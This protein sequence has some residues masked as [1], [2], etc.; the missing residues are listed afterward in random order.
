M[1][2]QSYKKTA[3]C[4]KD[5][6]FFI[7]FSAQ[8][9]RICFNASFRCLANL[10]PMPRMV[11]GNALRHRVESISVKV[12]DC[13]DQ[14]WRLSGRGKA[15]RG[16]VWSYLLVVNGI[17]KDIKMLQSRVRTRYLNQVCGLGPQAT[18][19]IYV[20][21]SFSR[22]CSSYSAISRSPTWARP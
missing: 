20:F 13:R 15:C 5:S 17:R 14:P 6:L 22:I 10:T 16:S 9:L 3:D 2:L 18:L 8:I 7:Q 1:M 19:T 11:C 4:K 12:A 21:F